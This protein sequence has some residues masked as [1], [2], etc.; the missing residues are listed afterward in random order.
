MAHRLLVSSLFVLAAC[1]PDATGSGLGDGTG[2]ATAIDTGLDTGAPDTDATDTGLQDTTT[3][4]TA[5]TDTGVDTGLDTGTTDTGLQDTTSPDTT[6]TDTGLQDTTTTDSAPADTADTYPDGTEFGGLTGTVWMPGNAPGMVPAGQ[7]IPVHGAVVYLSAER[8]SGIPQNAYC[9]ACGGAPPRSV[10]SDAR[11]NFSLPDRVAG[12]FWLVMQKGQFRLERQVTVPANETLALPASDTTLPSVYD[13]DNG[14]WIP[15]VAIAVGAFDHLEDIFGKLGLGSVDAS[16]GYETVGGVS[17]VDLWDNGG[18]PFPGT[19][20]TLEELVRDPQRLSQYHIIFIPC[21]GDDYVMA[22][23][24]PVVL[25]NLREYVR[26][27]GNLYVTDWSGEWSDNVFPAAVQLGAFVDTIAAAYDFASNTWNTL[28]FA[29]ADGD[30]YD[31]EHAQAVDPGLRQW[32]DGQIG[33]TA[34][35]E[36]PSTFDAD[37]FYVEGNWNTIEATPSY[38]VGVGAGG[39][40]VMDQAKVFVKGT[41]EDL[42]GGITTKPLTVTFEPAGCGRVVYSTYHTTDFVHV[43]LAPQERVLLYLIMEIGT[44]RY[45]KG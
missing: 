39:A 6:T 5:T 23:R 42:F 24:D 35:D 1:S 37:D 29:S 4:D 8:P 44:C 16:G 31:S 26:H 25:N 20:G 34:Q 17:N 3:T 28:L 14:K 21:S 9:E 12:T 32:L 40:A 19:L 2:D 7:E 45:T 18:F 38:Q 13:P 33:P 10:Y 41:V 27:G 11:G 43:G 15:R 30:A 36:S 22:L